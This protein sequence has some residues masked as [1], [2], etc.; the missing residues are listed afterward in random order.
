MSLAW[1]M[2]AS[3]LRTPSNR[4]RSSAGGT[5]SGGAAISYVEPADG[6]V[7]IIV[8]LPPAADPD[9]DAVAV[10]IGGASTT[11]TAESAG[12]SGAVARTAILVMDASD[13]MA[14]EKL[15]SA[16][17]A[18]LAYIDGLPADV[19]LGKIGRAHV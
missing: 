18:A 7:R 13:S 10:T 17:A 1:R 16:K 6:Q 15:A 19:S 2:P 4:H 3:T 14:G 9:L 8:S 12:T 11:A 5:P